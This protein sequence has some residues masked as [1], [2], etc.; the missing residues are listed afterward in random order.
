MCKLAMPSKM[1]TG[2]DTTTHQAGRI[3]LS[4]A[5]TTKLLFTSLEQYLSCF[6]KAVALT[7]SP[8]CL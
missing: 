4:D 1:L 7:A 6:P 5:M 8:A 2:T 3:S